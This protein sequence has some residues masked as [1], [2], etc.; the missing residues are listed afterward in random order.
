M[1]CSQ[2]RRPWVNCDLSAKTPHTAPDEVIE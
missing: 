1:R 2:A